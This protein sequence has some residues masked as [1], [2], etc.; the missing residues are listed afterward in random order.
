MCCLYRALR[1][2]GL[3]GAIF[4]APAVQAAEPGT[5]SATRAARPS[6]AE[7]YHNAA[8]QAGTVWS[9]PEYVAVCMRIDA[10]LKKSKSDLYMLKELDKYLGGFRKAITA[11]EFAAALASGKTEDAKQLYVET[12]LDEAVCQVPRMCPA[13]AVGRSL[14][15]VINY[16]ASQIR[17]DSKDL[18]ELL[19][20]FRIERDEA[21]M[22]V[23]QAIELQQAVAAATARREAA[24]RT[25]SCSDPAQTRSGVDA[26]IAQWNGRAVPPP[27]RR[28]TP[29]EGPVADGNCAVLRDT[30]A[31]EAMSADA[32]DALL[33]RC[34]LAQ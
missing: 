28:F 2:F 34:N 6:Q 30:R 18:T 17:S 5:M 14:G 1:V 22:K 4:L 13:W 7:N 20:D 32:Y 9:F 12:V 21:P 8:K 11:G 10:F 16:A 27:E 19:E 29:A 23:R 24:L 3:M 26:L 33:T 25:R 31:T 15:A